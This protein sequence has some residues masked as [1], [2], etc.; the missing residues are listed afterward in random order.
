VIQVTLEK[1]LVG[2]EDG[3][4]IAQYTG[5][6]SLVGWIRV[7]AVREALQ[8]RPK[9]KRERVREDVV[10]LADRPT[11]PPMELTLLRG[12][13]EGIFRAAVK[14]ALAELP[15][16]QRALLRL[17]FLEGLTI[18]DLAPLLGVHRATVTRRLERARAD[19]L[20]RTQA[21]LQSEHGFTESEAR[22]I[23][24]ALGSEVDISI[25]VAL[26]GESG[27]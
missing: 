26:Q 14:R 11:T 3:P 10:L 27:S 5:R 4:K 15:A 21:I 20:A 18:D 7:V 13:N 8:D 12:Q 6:G 9:S 24:Q 25:A 19:A 1:L 23:C 16:D 17:A 22:S 2:G